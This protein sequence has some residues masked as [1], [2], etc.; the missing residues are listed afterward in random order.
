MPSKLTIAF[1][2][3]HPELVPQV[4]RWWL[5]AWPSPD[6]RLDD[7]CAELTASLHRNVLPVHIVAFVDD[8]LVGTAALKPHELRKSYPELHGWLGS[9]FV[10]V[11][12]RGNGVATALCLHA[13]EL[14]RQLGLPRLHLQTEQLDGGLY[15]E[16]GW[17]PSER[18]TLKGIERVV[19]TRAV[20]PVSNGSAGGITRA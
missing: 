8:K 9:V 13:L 14:A 2:A 11:H 19:M 6:T 7:L 16:L 10:T 17:L 20:P 5:E 15:A 4:A 3:D 12:A 1:L 18:V